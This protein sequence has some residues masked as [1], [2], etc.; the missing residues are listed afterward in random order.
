VSPAGV[1]AETERSTVPVSPFRADTVIVEVAE[2]PAR[3][4]L[5]VAPADIVKSTTWNRMDP[6]S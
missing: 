5:G 3:I 4:W 6:L 1:D 2:S